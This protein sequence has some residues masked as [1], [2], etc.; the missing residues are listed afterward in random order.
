MNIK[1]EAIFDQ[2]YKYALKYRITH[3]LDLI[4]HWITMNEE[5]LGVDYIMDD[6]VD[7]AY[8]LGKK[9]GIELK[10]ED[11]SG[12]IG[13]AMEEAWKA[14]DEVLYDEFGIKDLAVFAIKKAK[15]KGE[16]DE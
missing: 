7:I 13:D 5:N 6:L 2:L 10:F 14:I 9:Y 16:Y 15:E 8:K 3:P 12:Y 4:E 11:I 1:G